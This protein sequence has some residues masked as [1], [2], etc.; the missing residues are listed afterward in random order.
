[1]AERRMF[2]KS[3]VESD[4]FLGMSHA[5]QALYFHLSMQADDDGFINCTLSVMQAVNASTKEMDELAGKGFIMQMG[6]GIYVVKHWKI[7]NI[8][9]KDRYKPT[10]YTEKKSKLNCKCNGA[11][12]YA[13]DEIEQ[14]SFDMSDFISEAEQTQESDKNIVRVSVTEACEKIYKAYPRKQGKAKGYEYVVAYLTNGRKLSGLSGRMKYNHEQLYCA[15][16]EYQFNCEDSHTEQKYIQMY[17][18]FMS[19]SV[20]EYIEN[21]EKGYKEYMRRTYGDE[22]QRLKFIYY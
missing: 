21:S 13:I 18:T 22:W 1:M 7:N 19:K 4:A 5:A 20:I 12:T 11:Y 16:R 3:I 9:Q 15:V 17:S 10:T 6:D 14:L 2:A 8:I